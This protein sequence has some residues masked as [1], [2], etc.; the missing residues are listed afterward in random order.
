MSD[1]GE[2]TPGNANSKDVVPRRD[3]LRLAGVALGAA[4]ILRDDISALP[5]EEIMCAQIVMSIT[6]L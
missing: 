1:S 3:F 5:E 4:F 6:S 2:K